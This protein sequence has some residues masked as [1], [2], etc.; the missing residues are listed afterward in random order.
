VLKIE[1]S[2]EEAAAGHVKCWRLKNRH[3]WIS[4]HRARLSGLKIEP[5][6]FNNIFP[7]CGNRYTLTDKDG[8][9]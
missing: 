2:G 6:D 8:K 9:W 3:Y 5:V 7:A 4:R 1:P